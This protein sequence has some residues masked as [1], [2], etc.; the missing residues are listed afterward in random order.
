MT[1]TRLDGKIAL[2]TGASRG[3]GAAIAKCLAAE[4]A[5]VCVHYASNRAA[6]EKVVK[7]IIDA[8]GR[9]AALQADLSK[10]DQIA[11]LVDAAVKQFGRIDIL[12]N[13]AAWSE[14]RTL[15]EIDPDHFAKHFTLNVRG[16]FF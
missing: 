5:S 8:G 9:A 13:N 10:L 7:S 4:G 14:R 2:I 1:M 3:I 11:P 12:V 6:A 15:A 16:L